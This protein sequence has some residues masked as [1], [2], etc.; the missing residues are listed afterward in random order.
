MRAKSRRFVIESRGGG[1]VVL[2][3]KEQVVVGDP[4]KSAVSA[5]KLAVELNQLEEKPNEQ[6]TINLS[7]Q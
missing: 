2:D 4:H 5:Y 1:W 7:A 6:S 3:Q